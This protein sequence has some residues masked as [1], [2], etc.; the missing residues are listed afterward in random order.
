MTWYNGYFEIKFHRLVRET[1][2]AY[3]VEISEDGMQNWV[4]KVGCKDVS[5]RKMSIKGWLIKKNPSFEHYLTFEGVRKLRGNL[6]RGRMSPS[7]GDDFE[8]GQGGDGDN[9]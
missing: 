7:E 9:W 6:G 2:K 5:S 3:L 4:P 8:Y 1:P